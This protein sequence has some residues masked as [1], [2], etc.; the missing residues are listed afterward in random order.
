MSLASQLREDLGGVLVLE[1]A[2]G[3]TAG[4]DVGHGFDADLQMQI[5]PV[6][7]DRVI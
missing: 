4:P 6:F 7:R 3:F 2:D 5:D 1:V